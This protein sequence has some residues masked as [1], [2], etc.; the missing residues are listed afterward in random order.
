MIAAIKNDMIRVISRYMK[1]EK[2]AVRITMDAGSFSDGQIHA[3]C[4][5]CACGYTYTVHIQQGALLICFL[6]TI[7][8]TTIF[9]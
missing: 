9:V 8:E 1:I 7:L 5:Y 4:L 2:D 6:T 3:A